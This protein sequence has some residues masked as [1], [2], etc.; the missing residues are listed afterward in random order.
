MKRNLLEQ[1]FGELRT[2]LGRTKAQSIRSPF[3]DD[4]LG[5]VQDVK[6]SKT[7]HVTITVVQATGERFKTLAR[8]VVTED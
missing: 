3:S 2:S 7:D 5:I 4:F 8:N 6:T 1:G